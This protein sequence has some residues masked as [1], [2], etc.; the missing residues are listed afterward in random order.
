MSFSERIVIHVMHADPIM[1]AGLMALLSGAADLALSSHFD[2]PSAEG[3][4]ELIITDYASALAACRRPQ[5]ERNGKPQRTLIVT[6][7]EKEW[8]VR[9]AIDAG[10][11]GYLLQ[12][13]APDELLKAVRLLSSGQRFLSEAVTRSVADSLTREN[14]T[15]RETD[16]L[17]LLA[18]GCC[19]KSIARELGIGVGTVKTH[20]KGLMSK[21][22]ATARTHAVVVATQRG[23]IGT[24]QRAARMSSYGT[25][26]NAPYR[27]MALQ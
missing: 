12:R 3:Q 16:V 20:V 2:Q 17:Q 24:C 9:S 15:G 26:Q 6:H 21:L 8:E 7:F 22:E 13:C 11:H 14:L 18:E 19:N 1:N 10:V 23:L 5:A 27:E 4:A 25:P